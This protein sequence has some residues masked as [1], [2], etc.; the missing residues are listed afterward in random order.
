[1]GQWWTDLNGYENI[2]ETLS[3]QIDSIESY[4]LTMQHMFADDIV[5]EER[6]KV[7]FYVPRNVYKRL[8]VCERERCHE[9]VLEWFSV[10]ERKCPAS[11]VEHV[12]WDE[13]RRCCDVLSWNINT[14]TN[15]S[16]TSPCW[17]ME[18][19]TVKAIYLCVECEREFYVKEHL[20]RH[21]LVHKACVLWQNFPK[22]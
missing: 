13:L 2:L 20:F 10:F 7:W 6:V 1:M 8:P 19:D 4:R 11:C 16:I 9:L 3:E 15:L 14:H 22:A 21:S 17:A 18:R 12:T 5:N